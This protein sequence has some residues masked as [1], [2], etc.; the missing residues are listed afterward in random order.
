MKVVFSTPEPQTRFFGKQ[1][2]TFMR[3]FDYCSEFLKG[4]LDAAVAR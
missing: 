4:I 3:F 1:G 2:S